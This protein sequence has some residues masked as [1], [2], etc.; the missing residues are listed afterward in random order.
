MIYAIRLTESSKIRFKK[1]WATVK[2]HGNS[3]RINE[4]VH[5]ADDFQGA[6]DKE[7]ARRREAGKEEWKK[8]FEEFEQ[9]RDVVKQDDDSYVVGGNVKD[10]GSFNCLDN[11]LAVRYRVV[12]GNF[13]CSSRSIKDA[14]RVIGG[15]FTFWG[16]LESLEGFPKAVA[17]DV[18]FTNY[19]IAADQPNHRWTEAEIREV[20]TIGGRLTVENPH[21]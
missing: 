20:C 7:V 14:P 16:E 1:V 9:R 19:P 5:M 15:N 3:T 10:W 17:G 11:C 6:D 21:A 12:G 18:V 8:E 13:D 4:E 2:E